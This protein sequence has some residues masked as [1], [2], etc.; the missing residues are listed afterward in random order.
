MLP[1]LPPSISAWKLLINRIKQAE[2]IIAQEATSRKIN[3]L[4]LAGKR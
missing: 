4:E 1:L 3:E 2:A